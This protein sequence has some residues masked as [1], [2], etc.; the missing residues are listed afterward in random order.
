MQELHYYMYFVTLM[1]TN[2][3]QYVTM[4]ILVG[5]I[6]DVIQHNVISCVAIRGHHHNLILCTRACACVR[7]CM[8]VSVHVHVVC[9]CAWQDFCFYSESNW[10]TVMCQLHH[11][12]QYMMVQFLI[13]ILKLCYAKKNRCSFSAYIAPMV[14][15]MVLRC[16]CTCVCACACI[17][18]ATW[19]P[20]EARNNF[21]LFKVVFF[22]FKYTKHST[23]LNII[24]HVNIPTEF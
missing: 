2:I 13:R 20:Y 17:M 22:C 23:V 1:V 14:S 16:V 19:P 3:L 6:N 18:L 12:Q 21:W 24:K 15:H 5:V 8:R 10:L 7:E 11:S 9:A 4:H